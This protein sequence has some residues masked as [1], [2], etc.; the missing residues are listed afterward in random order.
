MITTLFC[1]NWSKPL[2]CCSIVATTEG[3]VYMFYIKIHSEIN[4]LA[5]FYYN[6]CALKFTFGYK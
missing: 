6:N 3:N 1:L 2:N 5:G 4:G